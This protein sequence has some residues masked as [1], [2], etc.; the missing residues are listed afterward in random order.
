MSCASTLNI[1]RARSR[2]LLRRTLACVSLWESCLLK[3]LHWPH[4]QSLHCFIP[5]HDKSPSVWE[6]YEVFTMGVRPCW[7]TA[8]SRSLS[9]LE[10]DSTYCVTHTSTCTYMHMCANVQKQLQPYLWQ[11]MWGILTYPDMFVVIVA[12]RYEQVL[13]RLHA[14]Q[15]F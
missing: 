2:N 8:A 13:S 1:W 5:F 12:S 4:A 9:L 10:C 15:T 11:S 7:P 6:N 3:T 14:P